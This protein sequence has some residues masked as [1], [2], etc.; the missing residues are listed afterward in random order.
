MNVTAS[1]DRAGRL[2][3]DVV[4]DRPGHH[5]AK[6]AIADD[7]A[8]RSRADLVDGPGVVGASRVSGR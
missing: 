5:A 3:D 6:D 4:G 7:K 8:A 2:D 1:R